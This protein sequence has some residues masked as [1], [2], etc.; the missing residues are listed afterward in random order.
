MDEFSKQLVVFW[1]EFIITAFFIAM[2]VLTQKRIE[3]LHDRIDYVENRID[4]VERLIDTN[5]NE[6]VPDYQSLIQLHQ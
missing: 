3:L 4:R 6:V 2:L 5:K 1:I